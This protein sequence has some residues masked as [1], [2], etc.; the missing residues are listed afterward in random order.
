L[1]RLCQFSSGQVRTCCLVRPVISLYVS[2]GQLR[3]GY[4]MLRQVRLG[5]FTSGYNRLHVVSSG[6][7]ML[8]QILSG[9]MCFFMLF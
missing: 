1:F 2:L 6:E 3:T 4:V 7:E 8:H 5:Q 9:Y